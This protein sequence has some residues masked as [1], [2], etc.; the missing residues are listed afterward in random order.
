MSTNI[1]DKPSSTI[2]IKH[3]VPFVLDLDQM[4]YDI[5]RELFEI[6]CIGYG[7]D[8]HLK[9][10]AQPS[11]QTSDKDKEKESVTAK[12]TWLR[13]DSIVKSWLYETISISLLNMIFKRQ[14]TAFEVWESLEKV[15]RDNK[16]SKVIQLDREL[17]NISI[18][19]SSVT[20]YCNKIKSIA[21]R[22]EH[23]DAKVSDTNLVA[24]MING[25]SPKYRHIATTIRHRDSP[26]SFWDAR[27]ILICEEQQ[28]LLDEQRDATLTHVDHSSSP[29]ALTVQS[30]PQNNHTNGGRGG[31]NRGG[32][33]GR[34]NRGGRG[35][36]RHGGRFHNGGGNYFYGNSQQRG[37][38]RAW[39]YGWFQVH[40]PNVGSIQQGLLP[41]PGGV[42]NQSNLFGVGHKNQPTQQQPMA[43]QHQFFYFSSAQQHS[44][45]GF[46]GSTT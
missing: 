45:T 10:P 1:S 24:Y 28:M 46:S 25:L 15:F 14:E 20:D 3:A 35:G 26:P 16:A 40:Q 22:L 42:S 33:G 11:S 12:D 6:H 27:S 30:S 41:N 9:P 44:T 18:G 5:W 19:T 23:M 32:R 38:G 2:N 7:V 36:G 29:N 39:T 34:Y 21:D 4:N 43:Q 13:M 8:D 31:Y 17:R 37:T